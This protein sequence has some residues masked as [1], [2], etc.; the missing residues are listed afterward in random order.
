ML[1]TVLGAENVWPPLVDL[2]ILIRPSPAKSS[3]KTY[4]TP[5]WPGVV[6][7]PTKTKQPITVRSAPETG[8]PCDQVLPA[9]SGPKLST[10]RVF[11]SESRSSLVTG[12]SFFS[13]GIGPLQVC[14]PSVD[15]CT[16]IPH[17]APVTCE[18]GGLSNTMK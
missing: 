7:G 1:A 13:I 4:S 10:V 11:L 9:W 5:G 8:D 16:F 18:S 12:S 3:Q 2:A 6:G 15:L 14:P 17:P